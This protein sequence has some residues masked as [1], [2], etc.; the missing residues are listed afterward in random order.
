MDTGPDHADIQGIVARGYGNLPFACFLLLAV[1][2]RRPARELLA[3]WSSAVTSARHAPTGEATNI[4]FTA[5]GLLALL[6]TTEL[7]A[8]FSHPYL[9]GMTD[10]YR[11]RFL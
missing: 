3:A 7:P 8:G 10:P 4:A 9:A 5:A 2:E 11:S 1:E 6:G